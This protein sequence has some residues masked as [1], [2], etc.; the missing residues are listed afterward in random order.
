MSHTRTNHVARFLLFSLRWLVVEFH[1]SHRNSQSVL[2][3]WAASWLLR[4]FTSSI[5]EVP[6]NTA[7]VVSLS[8]THLCSMT[9]SKNVRH[10]VFLRL[11]CLIPRCDMTHPYAWHNSF[12]RVTWRIRLWER[13]TSQYDPTVLHSR[14][15]NV[16]HRDNK[17]VM[18]PKKICLITHANAPCH[19]RQR[20]TPQCDFIMLHPRLLAMC[21]ELYVWKY[22]HLY[23]R[24]SAHAAFASTLHSIHTPFTLHSHS[25]HTPFTLHSHSIHTPFTHSFPLHSHTLYTSFTYSFPFLTKIKLFVSA[26]CIV[27]RIVHEYIYIYAHIHIYIYI[28][29][30]IYIYIYKPST[31][32]P[33]LPTPNP[34]AK[35]SS[36]H[37]TQRA[38]SSANPPTPHHQNSCKK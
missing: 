23:A 19:T 14:T 33:P 35:L 28:Y 2:Y 32:V 24:E 30:H 21:V 36:F 11:T 26:L 38:H 4:R 16:T 20:L 27:H 10:D 5:Y 13:A 18:S 17:S 37:I 3:I 34:K 31:T 12:I 15:R 25:I 1:K 6:I 22:V 9:H 7:L 8:L 29:I